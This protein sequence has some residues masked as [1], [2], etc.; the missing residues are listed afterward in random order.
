MEQ[1]HHPLEELF[2]QLGL[3]AEAAAID[4]FIATHAPLAA[5][6]ALADAPFWTPAQATFLRE[7]ILEDADWAEIVDHLN[8]AL[9]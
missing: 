4:R 8:A 1:P 3:P 5:D 7:E 9:R 6:V 2:R